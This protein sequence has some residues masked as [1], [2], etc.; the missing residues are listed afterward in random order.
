VNAVEWADL[1]SV[2][3]YPLVVLR[4]IDS[5]VRR[6]TLQRV[7]G[8]G[9]RRRDAR[10]S[11]G[12]AVASAYPG[13]LDEVR[14]RLLPRLRAVILVPVSIGHELRGTPVPALALESMLRARG[15]HRV[16]GV[17][18]YFAA[19]YRGYD[20]YVIS[21]AGLLTCGHV[22]TGPPEATFIDRCPRRRHDTLRPPRPSRLRLNPGDR[23]ALL[24]VG[25][26][27]LVHLTPEGLWTRQTPAPDAGAGAGV[28]HAVAPGAIRASGVGAPDD[29]AVTVHKLQE[30]V[31]DLT[32][33]SIQR[34][35][36]GYQLTGH[37]PHRHPDTARLAALPG[38]TAV[39][40]VSAGDHT[41]LQIEGEVP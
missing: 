24:I 29:I 26:A 8:V 38:V 12:N 20:R 30:I 11:L 1:A 5:S 27:L 4:R 6:L 23:T 13:P 18:R 34:T 2:P 7:H 16:G 19:T 10:R 40:T 3:V 28:T 21:P 39:Q 31:P 36:L 33:R 37:T 25:A 35:K 41:E 9:G 14:N 32:L 17:R 15:A 22:D